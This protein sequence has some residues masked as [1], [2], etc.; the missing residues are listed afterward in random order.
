ADGQ[1]PR[2]VTAWRPNLDPL[3]AAWLNYSNGQPL[4]PAR[5]TTDDQPE[6]ATRNQ[7]S[8]YLRNHRTLLAAHI[9]APDQKSLDLDGAPCKARTIGPLQPAP[10]TAMTTIP[11]GRE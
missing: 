5:L 4:P 11:I 6:R 2:P 10:T 1:L 8:L 7:D 9:R 3:R